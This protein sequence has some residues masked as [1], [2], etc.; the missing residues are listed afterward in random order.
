MS[1]L[2]ALTARE[3][4][5]FVRQPSRIAGTVG[6]PLLFWVL[7][8]SGL[9]GSFTGT[10]SASGLPYS[11]FLLPG[12]VT[13]I[14]VFSTI[15]AAISLIQDRQAGFLQSVIVSATPTWTIVASKVAGGTLVALVQA[16]VLLLAAPLVGYEPGIAGMICALFAAGLASAAVIG[17]GLAAAWWINSTSGFHGVMNTVLM[18][19][20]LLSGA[21]FPAEGASKWLAF[22]MMCNPLAWATS[23]MS[24]SLRGNPASAGAAWIGS[25]AFAVCACLLAAI[26]MARRS[27]TAGAGGVE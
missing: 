15:F 21:I 12:M 18:P 26:V 23:A 3:L 20:W 10:G 14:V 9:S 1:A 16:A 2:L 11:A 6:T 17:I 22:I 7:A 13:M 5:R 25:A 8:A 27:T 19:M 4:K 24:A